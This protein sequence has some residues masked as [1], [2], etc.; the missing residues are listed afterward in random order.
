MLSAD[1]IISVPKLKTHVLTLYTGGV[2]KVFGH[3]PGLAKA[4]FHKRH[5]HPAAFAAMLT[6][7]YGRVRPQLTILDGI[8]GMEG[9]GPASGRPRPLGWLMAGSDAVAVDALASWL[10]GLEPSRVDTTQLA[11]RAALGEAD[12]QRIAIAGPDPRAHRRTDVA[13]PDDRWL[14]RVPQPVARALASLV[15]VRLQVDP[16]LCT[17]CGACVEMCPTWAIAAVRNAA[18]IDPHGCALCLGCREVCEE[19]AVRLRP[20][21]IAR[22][23]L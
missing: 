10:I 16:R 23:L 1:V 17:G 6:A 14:R 8:V 7:L 18:R 13:L 20:S 2:K 15:S 22:L 11:A 19:D 21:P 4:E 9:R 12:L 3:I 5:P